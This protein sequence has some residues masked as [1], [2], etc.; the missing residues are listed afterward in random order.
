MC[1][2][3]ISIYLLQERYV[4]LPYQS[5]EIVPVGINHN[6]IHIVG[7]CVEITISVE[8]ILIQIVQL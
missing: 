7:G 5:W 8:V 2:C 4:N 1:S 3:C 6:Y